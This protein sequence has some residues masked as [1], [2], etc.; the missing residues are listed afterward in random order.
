MDERAVGATYT[1]RAIYIKDEKGAIIGGKVC[2]TPAMC[3]EFGGGYDILLD[4]P[5]QY[6]EGNVRP[7]AA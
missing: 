4:I 6:A 2:D 7:V 3:G 5:E 1:L